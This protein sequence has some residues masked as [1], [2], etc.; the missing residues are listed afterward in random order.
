LQTRAAL[1]DRN[2]SADVKK[3]NELQDNLLKL[4]FPEFYNIQF[5]QDEFK[6]KVNKLANVTNNFAVLKG[7]LKNFEKVE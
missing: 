4:T 3:Y 5:P 2:D 6:R 7:K 1:L